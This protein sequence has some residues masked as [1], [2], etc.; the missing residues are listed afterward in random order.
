MRKLLALALFLGTTGSISA[1]A[2]PDAKVPL[3]AKTIE[4][5]HLK[6]DEAT[7]LLK[8][9]LTS[10]FGTVSSVSPTMPIIT[11]KD[12]PENIARMEKVLAKYDHSPATIRLV[13]QL[14]EADTGMRLV[15]AANNNKVSSDLDATLRSVLRF[16]SYRLIGQGMATTGEDTYFYQK[17]ATADTVGWVYTYD[18]TANVGTIRLSDATL[19]AGTVR[20]ASSGQVEVDTN[21]TGS[22][23]LKV[24]LSKSTDSGSQPAQSLF[25]TG[26]DLPLGQT[27]VLGTAATSR[28]GVALIL[29]V[30]PELVR[31]R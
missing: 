18:I 8:P 10:A 15:A 24:S 11:I 14:I 19:Q 23:S 3:E 31:S 25:S 27:V 13:F 1:Q 20:G 28:S 16:S 2:V 21:A 7:N 17:L 6:P 5:K 29:T 4:L 30:K 9:Y 22:V 12:S 26:L